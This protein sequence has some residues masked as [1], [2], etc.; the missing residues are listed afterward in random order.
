MN[1]INADS[2]GGRFV[3]REIALISAA[4]AALGLLVGNLTGLSASPIAKALIP[5]LFTLIGVFRSVSLESATKGPD[6][7]RKCNSV[8]L[9][10]VFDWHLYRHC[11]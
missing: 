1:S 11:S 8:I 2:L 7:S 10:C 9:N 5:A 6:R 4:F 3:N